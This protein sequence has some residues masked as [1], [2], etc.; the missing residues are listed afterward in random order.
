VTVVRDVLRVLRTARHLRPSQW[1]W[2]LRYLAT[3][4]L[5]E[6]PGS[7]IER[8]TRRAAPGRAEAA[9]ELPRVPVHRTHVLPGDARARELADGRLTL[10]NRTRE[11]RGGLDW[12]MAGERGANRLWTYNLHY[13][14]W[15]LDLVDGPQHDTLE[16]VL[17]DWL[18][19]CR[20]GAPGF[21]HFP[22]NSYTI[23]TR[24]EWWVRLHQALPPAFWER[25][26]GL[27]ERFLSSLASQAAYLHAHVEW[28]LRGNH[29]LRDARGLAWAARFFQGPQGERWSRTAAD[30]VRVQCEEQV[31]ADDGHFERSPMYHVHVMDDLLALALLL[32]EDDAVETACRTW[33]R[34]ARFLR[35]VRHPDGD[36]PLLNDAA[37]GASPRPAEMLGRQTAL[38]LTLDTSFPRGG[39]HFPETGLFVWH[40]EP[41]TVF[42]D[43]G[44]LGPAEQPGH[45]HADTLTVEC[46]LRGQRLFVDPGT[47]NYDRDPRRRYDRS[48][49]A[50]NTV[51]VDDLSSSE[52]WHIF[53][54]GRRARPRVDEMSFGGSVATVAAS[55]DGY[56]RLPGGPRHRRRVSVDENAR[57][58]IVDTVLG[59]GRHRLQGGFLLDPGWRAET[60]RGGWNVTKGAE[61]VAVRV[62]GPPGLRLFA[63][64]QPYHPRFGVEIETQRL[65][66]HLAAS[67]PVEV[68]IDV[69]PRP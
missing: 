64:R 15:L 21:T 17:V 38:G 10:L 11:F 46:S 45:G 51:C 56:E 28:D 36:I 44:P 42:F 52:V 23:A 3:R 4:R 53:R 5:E 61:R 55:H 66:W 14:E 50:H 43:V 19:T 35:W 41:W 63:E 58:E 30:V 12:R 47:Y 69:E 54:V 59:G 60:V 57:L 16:R 24:I 31:L 37:L 8:R 1:Y 29:L 62:T 25:T 18:D 32:D 27:R 6:A 39:A 49:A 13:H 48:T 34:M 26:R 33:A 40:G 2:R 9:T 7:G 65:S 20:L 68:R 67:L 22:W